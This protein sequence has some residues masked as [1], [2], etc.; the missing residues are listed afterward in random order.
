[1]GLAG[2]CGALL[3]SVPAATV[4]RSDAW[5]RDA[6]GQVWEGIATYLCASSDE[7][8]PS[9]R[10]LAVRLAGFTLDRHVSLADALLSCAAAK[11]GGARLD[12]VAAGDED[13]EWAVA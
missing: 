4:T 11:P 3:V 13:D 9:V 1:M 8:E 2:L 12:L 5:V 7:A 10:R 6:V